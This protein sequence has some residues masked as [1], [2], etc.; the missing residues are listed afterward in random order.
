MPEWEPGIFLPFDLCL[1]AWIDPS[2]SERRQDP[3]SDSEGSSRREIL[4][5]FDPGLL[6]RSAYA[7]G[8]SEVLL[9]SH[10]IPLFLVI[11]ILS[12]ALAR[13]HLWLSTLK[14]ASV[15]LALTSRRLLQEP[16]DSHGLTSLLPLHTVQYPWDPGVMVLSSFFKY[17]FGLTNLF[18][19]IKGQRNQR[20][21]L[22]YPR[23]TLR[24]LTS[25][26]VGSFT[27]TEYEKYINLSTAF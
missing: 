13:Q 18:H 19:G 9:L 5:E 6:G 14:T 25:C 4:S 7:L 1:A 27:D 15:I 26:R 24:L 16:F 3:L 22:L 23:I 12:G 21:Q 20:G 2:L 10:L 17:A 8:R 11:A